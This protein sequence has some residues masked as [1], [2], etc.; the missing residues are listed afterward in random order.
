ML[1]AAVVA[2]SCEA[3]PP[4]DQARVCRSVFAALHG[5]SNPVSLIGQ[6]ALRDG[7]G[8]RLAFRSRGAGGEHRIECRFRPGMEAGAGSLV[9]VRTDAGAL[10][11]VRLQLLK[12][13]WLSVPEG[14]AADPA[15]AI[16]S[17]RV[18]EIDHVAAALL[19][20]LLAAIPGMAVYGLL[21]AAYALIFGLVGRI[22]LAFGELAAL[23]SVAAF[24]AIHAVDGGVAAGLAAALLLAIWTG[25]AH[26]HAMARL[27]DATFRR[28][29]G[30]SAII[31]SIGVAIVLQEGVHR[32]QGTRTLWVPALLNGTYAIARAGD[33]VV[34]AT[35]AVA[36]ATV[37]GLGAGIGLLLA[38]PRSRF[39]RAW[40]ATADDPEAAALLGID[41]SALAARTFALA[42]GLA[43]LAG[44]LMAIR[45]GVAFTGGSLG[46]GLKALVAAVVGGIGSVPGAFAGGIVLA[47]AE[48]L[49]SA[50]LP[51]EHR[52]A[53][54]YLVLVAFLVL[55][56]NGMLGIETP[57]APR[58]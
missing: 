12:R 5:T 57:R 25:A 51:I 49:W 45:H 30:Q 13:F 42:A 52:D 32:L 41:A 37:V 8:V 19:D 58:L 36:L 20:L 4:A 29:S 44:A 34:T 55:R 1:A 28:S 23:G 24:L 40:R 56:P 16:G 33:L 50:T 54:I 21:A 14:L 6:Q 47:A 46:L 11:P 48:S 9:G 10:G 18:P 7:M 3:P 15:P 31:A 53:F 22:N 43:G 26:G 2:A 35:P 17:E 39:G 38:L 27:L